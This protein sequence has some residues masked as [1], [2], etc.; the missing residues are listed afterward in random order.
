MTDVVPTS[1]P[2]GNP[3]LLV[4]RS[5]LIRAAAVC[6]L[7]WVAFFNGYPIIFSDTASYLLTGLTFIAFW[8]FRSPGYSIFTKLASLGISAWLVIGAQAIILVYVLDKTCEYLLGNERRYREIILLASVSVLAALT[9]LPWLVSQLMPDVFAGIVFL[10]SYLL[11][12]NDPMPSRSRLSL[13]AILMISTG[14]HTSLLPIAALFVTLLIIIKLVARL[15]S[16]AILRRAVLASLIVPLVA[17]GLSTATLNYRMHLGFK[18]SPS[19]QIFMLSRL[20]ADGL[21]ADFLR[22]NCPKQPLIAC[23]YLSQ[24]PRTQTEFLFEN[25]PLLWPMIEHPDEMDEIVQGT[26]ANHKLRFLISSIRET[27]L[28]FTAFRTG[29]EVR[30]YH[31]KEW[32]RAV[33]AQVFPGDFQAFLN[34]KEI[35]GRLLPLANAAA[36]IDTVAFWLSV[37]LCLAFSWGKT[38]GRLNRFFFAAMAFLL[39]NAAVCATFSGVFDRYQSRVAWLAAL[40]ATTYV[41]SWVKNRHRAENLSQEP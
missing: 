9:S 33:A 2:P 16:A 26:L 36:A 12:F 38:M 10:T 13:A 35:R 11:A 7:L 41:C 6:A 14:V 4:I 17:A 31:A 24:L 40:C 20:F 25:H 32:N 34:S 22:E 19:G 1:Q 3:Y 21:A 23:G 15:R 37:V 27:F 30:S 28:Q 18:F 29:D 5:L 39:I 8:P